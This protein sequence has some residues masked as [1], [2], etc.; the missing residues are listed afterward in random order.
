MLTTWSTPNEYIE[1][2]V[3]PALGEYADDYDLDA[4]ADDMLELNT[5]LDEFGRVIA[6]TNKY[7]ERGG[8]DFWDVVERHEIEK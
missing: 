2:V 4:I 8:V 3:E 6:N 5:D 7:I 1:L